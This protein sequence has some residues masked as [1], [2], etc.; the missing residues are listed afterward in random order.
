MATDSTDVYS[1]IREML[2][3]SPAGCPDAPEIHE[4]LRMLFSED[5]AELVCNLAFMPRPVEAIAQKAGMPADECG[6]MLESMAARGV[7]LSSEREGV[8]GYAMLPVMPGLFEFP[9]MKGERG[10]FEDRLAVLWQSYS[11]VL[12]R[13]LGSPGTR[14]I[15]AIPVQEEV[16][17][18]PGILTH[19]MLYDLID[20]AKS[21]A[22]AHCACRE[23]ER[24][25]DS[26]RE[27]CMI[28]D[29]KA[30]FLVERGF[31]R[32]LTPDEMK[33]KLREFDR[34][35]LVHQVNNSA[36]KLS[37]ICNCC[38]CCCHLL[39]AMKDW[40]N[41]NVIASS[42]FVPVLD[43]ELCV[44]CGTCAEERCPMGAAAV[45]DDGLTY[46]EDRCIGCGLCVTGCP[47]EAL[48]LVKRAEAAPPPATARDMAL[49]LLQEKGRLQ[50]FIEINT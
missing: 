35:G 9:F 4:V 46:D 18:E 45:T 25:C 40:G 31:A 29:D 1:K 17:N 28:F 6:A 24:E 27:A 10:E 49:A 11:P 22:I 3:A 38:T 21:M 41:P 44:E 42:G 7:V 19:D 30:D 47:N 37:L 48:R 34:A 36:D 16:E 5:E 13:G 33:E 50:R 26:P 8:L 20:N 32:Y 2:D 23:S 39:R 12:G 43:A 14:L 15:R